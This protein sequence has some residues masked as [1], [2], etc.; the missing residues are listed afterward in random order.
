MT[1]QS[2]VQLCVMMDWDN[3]IMSSAAFL[4]SVYIETAKR[5]LEKYNIQ[6]L[7]P[8]P[9]F[10]TKT[11][12]ALLTTYFGED[13]LDKTLP[14]FDECYSEIYQPETLKM[15]GGAKAFIEKLALANVPLAIISN[16]TQHNIKA[17]LDI[18][19][20]PYDH[21]F[22]AG[23]YSHGYTKPNP[24]LGELALA[25]FDMDSERPV[26]V[27]MIGDGINSDML[28]ADNLN[29]LLKSKNN[30]SMCT[31]LLYNASIEGEPIHNETDIERFIASHHKK[32]F[33]VVVNYGYGR[34]FQQVKQQLTATEAMHTEMASQTRSFNGIR[35]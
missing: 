28:F 14:I 23:A 30:E 24:K 11:K 5:V 15:L 31:G 27:L 32:G 6:L 3:T 4:K 16:Y 26:K 20:I 1:N 2:K 10:A 22:I 17:L 34:I 7:E 19:H 9:D 18:N 12:E 13:N 33:K 8:I 21:M 29:A 25:H 35:K